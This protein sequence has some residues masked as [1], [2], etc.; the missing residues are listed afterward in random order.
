MISEPRRTLFIDEFALT[1]RVGIV[2]GA[3]RGLGLDT[4]MAFMEAGARA[5]YC[6]DISEKPG[7]DWVRVRDYLGRVDGIGRLEY[8]HGDVRSQVRLPTSRDVIVTL[9]ISLLPRLT[10]SSPRTVCG[11]S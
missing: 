7:E 3:N 1:D 5:I 11:R 4:E 2:T 10:N 6:I 8:V 9:D